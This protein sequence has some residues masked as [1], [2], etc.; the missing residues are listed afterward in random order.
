VQKFILIGQR[1]LIK[2]VILKK[3]CIDREETKPCV[4]KEQKNS[5]L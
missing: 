5:A 3:R 2:E 1:G 4:K